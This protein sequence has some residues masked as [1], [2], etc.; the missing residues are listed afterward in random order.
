MRIVDDEPINLTILEL[1]LKELNHIEIV[2]ALD[3]YKA[4]EYIEDFQ[5]DLI[6]LDLSM[7]ELIWVG[8]LKDIEGG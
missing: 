4:L 2:S 8:G 7:P 1:A 3:G 5:I 6:I